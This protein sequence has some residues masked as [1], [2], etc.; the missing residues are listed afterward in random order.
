MKERN[1]NALL[2]LIKMFVVVIGLLEKVIKMEAVEI[3]LKELGIEETHWDAEG[4]ITSLGNGTK[5]LKG[6]YKMS[7]KDMP[8]VVIFVMTKDKWKRIGN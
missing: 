5:I 2:H 1:V 4:H 6:W 7:K 3:L 8:K